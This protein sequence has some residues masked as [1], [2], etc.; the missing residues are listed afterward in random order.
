MR[1]PLDAVTRSWVEGHKASMLRAAANAIAASNRWRARDAELMVKF[2]AE[3]RTDYGITQAK[4]A[5]PELQ[6][7]YGAFTFFTTKT[8]LHAAALQGALAARLLLA[9]DD[10]AGLLYSRDDDE[11]ARPVPPGVDGLS[12]TGRPAR[13]PSPNAPAGPAVDTVERRTHQSSARP[14]STSRVGAA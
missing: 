5:D 7:A 2:R 8:Q 6:D 4:A 10:P 14:G 13:Q 11:P 9:D 12:I 1:P 3:K